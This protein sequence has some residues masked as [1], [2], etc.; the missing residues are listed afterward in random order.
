MNAATG[1]FQLQDLCGSGNG[2]G[3]YQIFKKLNEPISQQIKKM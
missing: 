2:P 3:S 1:A